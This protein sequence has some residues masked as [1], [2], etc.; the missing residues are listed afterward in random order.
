[1]E[2]WRQHR[3]IGNAV[4]GAMVGLFLVVVLANLSRT[5]EIVSTIRT[6]Q[7]TN[8]QINLTNRSL[9]HEV[10]H[11]S[12]RIKSCTTPGEK[13]YDAG[14]KRTGHA[15]A[16]INRVVIL[17]AA[18]AVG[19]HGTVAEIQNAIQ[20]CVIDRLAADQRGSP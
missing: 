1:M 4:I 8:T 11:L 18:C 16:N 5:G 17:A 13:C 7:K 12:K 9:L 15:V 20:T 6:T 2:L 19:Q 14:Q 3:A 10:A